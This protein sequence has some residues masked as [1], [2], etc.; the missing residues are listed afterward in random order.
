MYEIIVDT[1]TTGLDKQKDSPIQIAFCVM[2][3]R[4]PIE[5]GTFLIRSTNHL[6]HTITELTGITQRDLNERGYSNATATKK[7][8]DF[9]WKWQPCSLVG[10]NLINFDFPIIFN[11][12]DRHFQG[13]FKHPPVTSLVDT[14]HLCS[15]FFGVKKWLRLEDCASRLSIKFDRSKLHNALEDVALT[16]AVYLAITQ[17]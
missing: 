15:T 6:D 14:M 5:E 1:E 16:R 13:H 9:I 10:H 2:N 11:W 12:M 3:M 7:W 8:M 17:K 4:K